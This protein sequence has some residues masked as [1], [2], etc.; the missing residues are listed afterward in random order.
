[1]PEAVS[2]DG[3]GKVVHA[4]GVGRESVDAGN[5]EGGGGIVAESFGGGADVDKAGV[6]KDIVPGDGGG[7]AAVTR[8]EPAASLRGLLLGVWRWRTGDWRER[9]FS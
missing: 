3:D 2:Q 8:V 7:E 4:G 9:G 1:M 5:E 6:E